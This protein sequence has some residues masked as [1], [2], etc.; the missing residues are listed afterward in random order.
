MCI[1]E[2]KVKGKLYYM[3]CLLDKIHFTLGLQSH[4]N[5]IVT[6]IMIYLIQNYEGNADLKTEQDTQK[7]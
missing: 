2:G 3:Y 5:F 4:F 7:S 6:D 1:D